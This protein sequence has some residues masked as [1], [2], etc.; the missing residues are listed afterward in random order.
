M[1]MNRHKLTITTII[2]RQKFLFLSSIS[3]SLAPLTTKTLPIE[4]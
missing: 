2:N 4:P 1:T 3:L